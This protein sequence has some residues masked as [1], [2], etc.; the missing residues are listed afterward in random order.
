MSLG[1]KQI[2]LKMGDD[3]D[4]LRARYVQE[5][6][7][8]YAEASAGRQ[9]E[10]ETPGKS[11]AVPSQPTTGVSSTTARADYSQAPSV[12]EAVGY[13]QQPE[14]NMSGPSVAQAVGLASPLVAASLAPL[15]AAQQLQ[16]PPSAPLAFSEFG[17]SLSHRGGSQFLQPGPVALRSQDM[18]PM[19]PHVTTHVSVPTSSVALQQ[20]LLQ[21]QLLQYQGATALTNLLEDRLTNQNPNLP[22]MYPVVAAAANPWPYASGLRLEGAVAEDSKRSREENVD[23][24]EK[25]PSSAARAK[26]RRTYSHESFP[27]RLYR[28]LDE[29]KAAGQEDIISWNETGDIFRIHR[30]DALEAILPSYFRHSNVDSFKRQLRMYGFERLTGAENSGSYRHELFAQGNP[31]LCKNMV[32]VGEEE[33]I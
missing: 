29:T 18:S 27:Q 26:K 16:L 20:L 12:R 13:A 5:A 30:P 32:R 6:L 25:S 33:T 7:R 15:A 21:Q 11:E 17:G 10:T 31:E 9:Q 28:L 24:E 8:K 3:E 19:S 22:T 14:G 2:L 23:A 4:R 1:P